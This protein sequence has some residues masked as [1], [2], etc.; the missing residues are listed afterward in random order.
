ME[1]QIAKYV[2]RYVKLD[3]AEHMVTN[4]MVRKNLDVDVLSLKF[5]NQNLVANFIKKRTL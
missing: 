1:C 2:I 5:F 3:L 4:I